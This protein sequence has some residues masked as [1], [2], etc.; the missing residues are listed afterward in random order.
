MCPFMLAMICTPLAA[1]PLS[2]TEVSD[3]KEEI[4]G[5]RVS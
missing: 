1:E 4:T 2:D 5:C 3:G